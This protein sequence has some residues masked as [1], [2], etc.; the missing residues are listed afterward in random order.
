MRRRALSSSLILSDHPQVA[1]E[2]FDVISQDMLQVR[3]LLDLQVSEGNRL[4]LCQVLACHLEQRHLTPITTPYNRYRRI[5]ENYP[6][7]GLCV[8]SAEL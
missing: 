7:P 1:V 4:A 3:A 2:Y 5:P 8:A 6:N